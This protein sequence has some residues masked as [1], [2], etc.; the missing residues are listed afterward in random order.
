MKHIKFIILVFAVS[1]ILFSCKKDNTT[2]TANNTVPGGGGGPTASFSITS[3]PNTIGYNWVYHFYAKEETSYNNSSTTYTNSYNYT[4]TV[5]GDTVLSSNKAGKIWALTFL[6]SN[7]NCRNVAY[8]DSTSNLFKIEKIEGGFNKYFY[9]TLNYPLSLNK[10]W[11]NLGQMPLDTSKVI[12]QESDKLIIDRG[13]YVLN[14]VY[15]YKINT[16]GIVY[17]SY[18]RVDVTGGQITIT[19]NINTLIS[20]NF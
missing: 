4:V 3:Y 19:E 5:I 9:T 6:N 17:S 13:Y 2:S 16:K 14:G 7:S 8:L 11:A 12:G 1:S 15:K 10:S 20:T 18:Y